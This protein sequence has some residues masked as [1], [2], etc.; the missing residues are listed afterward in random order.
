MT[1]SYI[2]FNLTNPENY[3]KDFTFCISL[4]DKTNTKSQLYRFMA[5]KFMQHFKLAHL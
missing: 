3:T 2:N 1:F 5:D 4:A